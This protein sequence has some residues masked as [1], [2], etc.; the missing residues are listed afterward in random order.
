[1]SS[2]SQSEFSRRDATSE[3]PAPSVETSNTTPTTNINTSNRGDHHSRAATRSSSEVEVIFDMDKQI[4]VVKA[5]IASLK[6]EFLELQDE[7][8]CFEKR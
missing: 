7:I 1:M 5:S 6:M 2:F 8:H 4:E 3:S